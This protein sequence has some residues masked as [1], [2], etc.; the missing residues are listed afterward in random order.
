MSPISNEM[1]VSSEELMTKFC[2]LVLS[3]MDDFLDNI[4]HASSCLEGKYKGS[5]KGAII[6]ARKEMSLAGKWLEKPSGAAS[7]SSP[8]PVD[9]PIEK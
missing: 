2:K 1:A 8:S 6:S 7:T 3:S 9:N 5:L 4:V